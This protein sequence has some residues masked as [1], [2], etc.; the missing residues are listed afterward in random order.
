M[1][2][3][4]ADV[5]FAGNVDGDGIAV[6]LGRH[7]AVERGLK[8]ADERR[9]WQKRAE[10]ADGSEVRR[11]VR[12]GDGAEV[13]H[14]RE[15]VVRQQLHAAHAPR[16]HDLESDAVQRPQVGQHGLLQLQ[17]HPF[18]GLAV[19]GEDGRLV[20]ERA[21]FLR[22]R[23][24]PPRVRPDT[25]RPAGRRDQLLRHP[26]QLILQRRTAHIA[27]QNIHTQ[28][29]CFF[30]YCTRFPPQYQCGKPKGSPFRGAGSAQPRLRGCRRFATADASGG[31]IFSLAREKIGEKRVRGDAGCI[32]PL[33]LGKP[34]CFGLAFHSVVTLRVSATRRLIRGNQIC[35]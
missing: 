23:V 22:F 15:H 3:V 19:R 4:A 5:V 34:Q 24:K 16:Q 2:A 35:N 14:P 9:I 29:P 6:R 33:N 11:V 20:D 21:V 27:D 31:P 28:A 17:Q 12:G 10:L 1:E 25:L 26:E 18:D 8:R 30:L 13:L 32:L 7:R